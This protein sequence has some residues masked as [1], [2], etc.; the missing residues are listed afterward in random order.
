M[1]KLADE[2]I[3]VTAKTVGEVANNVEKGLRGL[4]LLVN[5]HMAKPKNMLLKKQLKL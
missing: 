4:Q 1:S 2:A 5:L 3:K